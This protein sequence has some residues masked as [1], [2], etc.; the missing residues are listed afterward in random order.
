MVKVH[1]LDTA[2][3]CSES[4]P[5]KRSGM[6]RVLKVSHTFTCTTTRTFIRDRNAF[7]ALVLIYLPRRDGRLSRLWCEVFCI[8]SRF[9]PATY[10]L[11]IRQSTTQPLVHLP[12]SINVLWLVPSY[13]AWYQRNMGVNNLPR[14]ASQLTEVELSNL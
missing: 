12:Q 7:P 10:R 6:A 14:V 8:R 1:T 2:P 9:E 13:T 4:S 11:Q 3:L 5:Q